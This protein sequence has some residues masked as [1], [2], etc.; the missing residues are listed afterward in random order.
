V[1][2]KLVGYTKGQNAL[3]LKLR[4]KMGSMTTTRTRL[5]NARRIVVQTSC[6]RITV[7]IEE[8]VLFLRATSIVNSAV[9]SIV[10]E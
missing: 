9:P 5:S 6:R 1:D 10:P 8:D 3:V 4:M 7:L 2:L